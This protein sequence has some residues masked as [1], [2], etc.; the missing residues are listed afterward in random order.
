MRPQ[1][2]NGTAGAPNENLGLIGFENRFLVKGVDDEAKNE[3]GAAS[4]RFSRIFM[5]NL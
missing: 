1:Y 5:S 4:W 3:S 2:A